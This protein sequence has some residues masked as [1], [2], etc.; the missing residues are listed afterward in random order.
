MKKNEEGQYRIGEK[1]IDG[2]SGEMIR[3]KKISMIK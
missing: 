2:K 1:K 3:A